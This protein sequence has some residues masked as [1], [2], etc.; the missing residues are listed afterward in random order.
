MA[1][2]RGRAVPPFCRASRPALG[3]MARPGRRAGLDK[4]L[5]ECPG[6]RRIRKH[7][8]TRQLVAILGALSKPA[9]RRGKLAVIKSMTTSPPS[10]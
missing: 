4:R 7:V 10:A 9:Q 6:F 5:P 2:P 8:T 1:T 3:G